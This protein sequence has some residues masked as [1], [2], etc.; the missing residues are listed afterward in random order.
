VNQNVRAGKLHCLRERES[1][2][3]LQDVLFLL[4]A[5]SVDLS[6]LILYKYFLC[7]FGGGFPPF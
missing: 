2:F 3:L 7:T 4:C 6:S 1:T 5:V